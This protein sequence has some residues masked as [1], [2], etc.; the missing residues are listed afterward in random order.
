M[1]RADRQLAKLSRPRIHHAVARERLFASL[2]AAR[3]AYAGCCVVGPP[4]AGKTTLVAS[5]LDARDIPGI[6]YQIDAADSDLATFFH[7]L[8]LAVSRFSRA[9][10]RPLPALTPEYAADVPGFAR[11][12]FRE[13][14]SRLLSPASLVFDN[15]QEV[16]PEERLHE[17][18]SI[19]VSELPEDL[20]LLAIS[21]ADPPAC[22]ARLIA[23]SR[24]TL[25]EWDELRFTLPETE[26]MARLRRGTTP[27]LASEL[28]ERTG[29]WAAGLTLMLERGH[30]AGGTEPDSLRS[31][32]A[33][34][35]YFAAEVFDRLDPSEQRALCR[36]ALLPSVSPAA[37][38][39]LSG[40]ER[41]PALL[42]TL[43]RR[44]LF[45]DRRGSAEPRYQYHALFQAFLFRRLTAASSAADMASLQARAAALLVED[46]QSDKAVDVLL[47]AAQYE[48]AA[49]LI[50]NVAPSLLR[51]GRWKTVR[52]WIEAL[53]PAL[54]ERDPWLVFWLGRA[55]MQEDPAQSQGVLARAFAAFEASGDTQGQLRAAAAVLQAIYFEYLDFTQMDRWVATL[56]ALLEQSQPCEPAVQLEI[57]SPLLLAFTYRMPGHPRTDETLDRLKRLLQD[58]LEVNQI[59]SA[60]IALMMHYTLSMQV[61]LGRPIVDRIEPLIDGP[62]ATPL[63]RAYWWNLL[64]YHLYRRGLRDETE[65]AFE[66][67]R[68]IAQEHGL[69]HIEFLGQMFA[70]Y[71]WISWRDTPRA[72]A[73]LEG[74]HAAASEERPMTAAQYHL[75]S[76]F[77]AMAD[78]DGAAAASHADI[79][80]RAAR[81]LGSPFHTVVWLAQASAA[82]AMAG[83][84]PEAEAWL[85]EALTESERSFMARYRSTIWM[86][87]AYCSM[88]KN[89]HEAAHDGIAQMIEAGRRDEGWAYSRTM[90]TI[91]DEVLSEAV[92]ARIE[93]DFVAM[94]IRGLDAR[95]CGSAL[96]TWPRLVRIS[97]LG[98]FAVHL[99]GQP[100]TFGRKAQRRPLDLLKALIALGGQGVDASSLIDA[101]W[102]DAQGDD[103][104]STLRMAAWRLR[105]L[106]GSERAIRV[107]EGKYSIDSEECWIDA[108]AL[109]QLLDEIETLDFEAMPDVSPLVSRLAALYRGHFLERERQ[110]HWILNMQERLRRRVQRAIV[111]LGTALEHKQ[112]WDE[113]IAI[114]ERGLALDNLAEEIYRRLMV[115]Y[116]ERGDHA[117]AL[118]VY[119]RCRELLSV[120]LGI[121]PSSETQAIGRTLRPA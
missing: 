9:G 49:T 85:R 56:D 42:D 4:G 69:R 75:A 52:L 15:Y 115:C 89:D 20:M 33:V 50:P 40:D 98:T 68:Q 111:R 78:C 108:V 113:A 82:L 99:D 114:Y 79:A 27:A 97:T 38:V 66:R 65:H 103:A 105:R 81:R 35:D 94:M 61:S 8:G 2:D 112:R 70:A 100:L 6:W 26:A 73:A 46:G 106:L 55:R 11:R 109:G 41:A 121:Q 22:Y 93:P 90:A 77:V 80:V 17:V 76:T 62:E 53:G 88:L 57:Y 31:R 60:G 104:H 34:F 101:L 91:K 29:G 3:A 25:L 67:G 107:S 51:H 37:A 72:R 110:D 30:D 59:I 120:V 58:G 39:A 96:D 19:A 36:T 7:Y 24:I 86:S 83:R 45:T 119:R 95:P 87:I 16:P 84:I 12:F 74:W 5:W 92:R 23:N 32:D 28:H 10:Q 18:L 116:R 14:A 44:H 117:Q 54:L 63:N 1:A 64:G 71:Y 118:E 102:P 21:R 13:L 43:Y 47:Q 48:A